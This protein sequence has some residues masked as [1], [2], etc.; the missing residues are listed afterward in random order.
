MQQTVPTRT[1]DKAPLLDKTFSCFTGGVDSF[2]TLVRNEASIDA[3]VYDH[4][5]DIVLV[6]TDL[7][8]VTSEHLHDVS[9]I[10][11]KV[12]IEVSTNVRRFLDHAGK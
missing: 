4:G 2:D 9:S 1:K 6:R 12:L 11:G 7:R 3:L 8:E 10:T 5:F